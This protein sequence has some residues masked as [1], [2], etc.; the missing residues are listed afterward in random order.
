M[1]DEA[2]KLEGVIVLV[3]WVLSWVASAEEEGVCEF[4]CAVKQ[5]RIRNIRSCFVVRRIRNGRKLPGE[6][7]LSVVVWECD[8]GGDI[9]NVK[10][11]AMFFGW[12]K[13]RGVSDGI[14]LVTRCLMPSR[15]SPSRGL[16]R[17][18]CSLGDHVSPYHTNER[19]SSVQ[20]WLC[21][22]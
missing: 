1:F 20:T 19:P 6:F 11:H 4:L 16:S 14:L 18:T 17:K 12:D 7:S 8:E 10:Q 15:R 5:V 9:P 21:A 3:L 2:E 13:S 22:E